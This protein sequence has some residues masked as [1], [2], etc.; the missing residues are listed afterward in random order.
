MDLVNEQL[1]EV[2]RQIASGTDFETVFSEV[3]EGK[4]GALTASEISC[5]SSQLPRTAG[6]GEPTLVEEIFK[7]NKGEIS[8]NY[9]QQ[10]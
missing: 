5:N 7:L 10:T 3:A 4:Y 9:P 8:E 2:K 1:G 6:L